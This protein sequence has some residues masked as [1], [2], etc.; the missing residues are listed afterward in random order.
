MIIYF[1]N[2][3]SALYSK[4]NELSVITL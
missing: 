3:Y 4:K 1:D 2:L